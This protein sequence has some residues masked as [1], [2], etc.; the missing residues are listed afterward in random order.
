MGSLENVESDKSANND[1]K[2][3][4][5][6][7][8]LENEHSEE[9]EEFDEDGNLVVVQDEV[10]LQVIVISTYLFY[11]VEVSKSL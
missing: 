10:D 7:Y 6:V 4:V 9:L 11:I 2:S 1:S 5:E 3:E 8:D